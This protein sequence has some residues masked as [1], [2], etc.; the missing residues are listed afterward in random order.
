MILEN[1]SF[2]LS[3]PHGEIIVRENDDTFWLCNEIDARHFVYDN[4][5]A[6]GCA[7]MLIWLHL[8]YLLLGFLSVCVI[9]F[10]PRCCSP[11]FDFGFHFPASF[12][13]QQSA[14]SDLDYGVF[15]YT[16][17]GTGVADKMYFVNAYFSV[18]SIIAFVFYSLE[19]C[20]I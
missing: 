13:S 5:N 1:L 12:C 2:S 17:V 19:S 14:D 20:Y 3:L 7:L 16:P 6:N 15:L 11:W 8:H 4:V 10:F 9:G 18:S